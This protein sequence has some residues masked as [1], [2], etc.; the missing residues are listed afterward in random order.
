MN[1]CQTWINNLHVWDLLILVIVPV[2]YHCRQ[3]A[4]S[5]M[6]S[7]LPVQVT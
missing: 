4:R 2:L 7:Q 5:K 1:K 3:R 6:F